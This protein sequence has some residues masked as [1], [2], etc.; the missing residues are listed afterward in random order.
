MASIELNANLAILDTLLEGT[1]IPLAF[2]SGSQ[3]HQGRKTN[4]PEAFRSIRAIFSQ[5]GQF[6]RIVT[7]YI[8]WLLHGE[9]G[10]PLS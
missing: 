2:L 10:F 8:D 6:F 3:E 5:L 1:I 4:G 7:R 9:R